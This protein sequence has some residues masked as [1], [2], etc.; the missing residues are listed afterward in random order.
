MKEYEKL[1]K[2]IAKA[3]RIKRQ[4]KYYGD[5]VKILKHKI[6]KLACLNH[7]TKNE[8][9]CTQGCAPLNCII[10]VVA[11]IFVFVD[12]ILHYIKYSFT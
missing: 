2:V 11:R 1:D 5:K 12:G 8:Q 9:R 4:I 10:F 6:P 3:E 7:L